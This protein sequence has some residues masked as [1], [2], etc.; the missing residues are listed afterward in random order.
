MKNNK[1]WYKK[2]IKYMVII[3]C[4]NDVKSFWLEGNL[5]IL[6]MSLCQSTM[7]IK[8]NKKIK[9]KKILIEINKKKYFRKSNH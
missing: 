7:L 5:I 1:N 6:K 2:E 3:W 8:F 4:V 9:Y